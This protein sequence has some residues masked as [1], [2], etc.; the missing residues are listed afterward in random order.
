MR[1]EASFDQHWFVDNLILT[2]LINAMPTVFPV[3][4]WQFIKR[5][6]VY[7]FPIANEKLALNV[8]MSA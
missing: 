7:G 4:E 3:G 8:G 2:H 6:K 1:L 5:V